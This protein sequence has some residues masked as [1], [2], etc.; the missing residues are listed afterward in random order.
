[1]TAGANTLVPLGAE[2]SG[3]DATGAPRVAV[4]VLNWNGWRDTTACLESV[5]R[6]TYPNFRVVVC[7]NASTDGSPERLLAWAR[8]RVTTD[9]GAGAISHL[10]EVRWPSDGPELG[11]AARAGSLLLVHTGGNWGFA[12]GNNVG[13][14]AALAD[15]D[16]EH[17]WLLNNDT[18]IEPD[19]IAELVAAVAAVGGEVLASSQVRT[20]EN[21][22]VIWFEGGVYSPWLATARH[23]SPE[24]FAAASHR[25]L[26]GCALLVSRGALLRL[27]LLDD[28]MFMYAED[29]DYSAK[30]ARAGV[31]LV[32]APRSVVLHAGGAS[33][34]VASAFAYRHHVANT[35]RAVTRHHGRSRLL[36]IVPYHVAKAFALFVWKHRSPTLLRAYVDGLLAGCR[37]SPASPLEREAAAC[38]Q[39]TRPRAA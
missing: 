31:P 23:V 19:A 4:V 35:V 36:T 15:P 32:L 28:T 24:R 17:V 39:R 8:A 21:P 2:G 1:M 3:P 29:V 11:A 7:D 38:L 20:M 34:G 30:A 13:V 16:V 27:G 10:A 9:H 25:Y 37:G 14:E 18:V 26:S 12:G 5:Y 33:S 22:D 6:S